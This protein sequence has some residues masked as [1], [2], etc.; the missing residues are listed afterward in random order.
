MQTKIYYMA[1]FFFFPGK[2]PI[3]P[4]LGLPALSGGSPA[5]LPGPGSQADAGP[6]DSAVVAALGC[7][8]RA[9]GS[10]SPGLCLSVLGGRLCSRST[11]RRTPASRSSPA[12]HK[13]ATGGS[14]PSRG[15]A[16]RIRI[17]PCL[18]K[19]EQLLLKKPN[20][21]RHRSPPCM[22]V[23]TA[24]DGAQR[25]PAHPA[26]QIR[27]EAFWGASCL[28]GACTPGTLQHLSRLKSAQSLA[29]YRGHVFLYPPLFHGPQSLDLPPPF[30]NPIFPV[31]PSRCDSLMDRGCG[32]WELQ[33][34]KSVC[35]QAAAG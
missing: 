30:G 27:T 26:R 12:W 20:W 2:S 22:R 13:L 32:P 18:L 16:K 1:G 35:T 31:L 33:G 28:Q 29:F 21:E 25:D 14:E 24:F 11:G 15:K 9:G 3:T 5:C 8:G 10:P 23:P 17:P 6:G 34:E 4:G 7:F 19:A